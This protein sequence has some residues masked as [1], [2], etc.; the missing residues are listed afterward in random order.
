MSQRPPGPLERGD[1]GLALEKALGQ[2]ID[3]APG[4]SFVADRKL[5]RW[6]AGVRVEVIGRFREMACAGWVFGS[7]SV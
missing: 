7:A 2:E 3:H 4:G 6:V 1:R 5:A